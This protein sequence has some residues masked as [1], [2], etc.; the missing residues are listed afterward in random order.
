MTDTQAIPLDPDVFGPESTC[1]GCSPLH[2][3]GFHLRFERIGEDVATTFVPHDKLQGPP[4][5]M[6]GGL[7]T[8]LADEIAAWTVIA[9]RE[10]FGFTG[11]IEAKLL[12]P[13]RIGEP[14]RGRGRITRDSGRTLAIEVELEQAG[15]I[16]Y[17]GMFTFVVLD[18]RGA[19][20]LLGGPLPEAWKRF[21]RGSVSDS[22]SVKA[23]ETN[24]PED[25]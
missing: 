8:T 12:R 7:V 3:I 20:R 24:G 18:E 4:G 11:A 13:V 23:N 14:V 1:F 16:A 10:R 15:A 25:S 2:P 17:R 19:E 5:L 6:H 22:P 9:L 21:A